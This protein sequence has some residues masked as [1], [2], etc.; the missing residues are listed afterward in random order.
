MK[1]QPAFAMS[2]AHPVL[3]APCSEPFTEMWSEFCYRAKRVTG[4]TPFD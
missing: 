3:A 1:P 4:T 2:W